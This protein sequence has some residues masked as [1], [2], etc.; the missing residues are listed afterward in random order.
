[1]MELPQLCDQV[2]QLFRAHFISSDSKSCAHSGKTYQSYPNM[3][4]YSPI[5]LSGF[6]SIAQKA[7]EKKSEVDMS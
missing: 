6:N 3:N 1:M 5:W 4:W 7:V 2:P